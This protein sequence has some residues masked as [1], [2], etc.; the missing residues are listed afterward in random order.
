MDPPSS[1]WDSLRKQARIFE[2]QLDDQMHSY[3]KLVSTK[4]DGTES[5][6]ESGIDRLLKQLQQVNLQM[7]A[8]VSSGGSDIF[9]HT[10]TR[11]QEILQDLNQE[12]HRLRSSL[13]AKQEHASLLQ[14]F[15]EFDRTRLDLEDGVGS[16]EQALLREHA[17]INRNTGQ[18]VQRAKLSENPN[19]KATLGK[20]M[21]IIDE[22]RVTKGQ[23]SPTPLSN[24]EVL[25]N[26][27]L[28]NT[29]G[30]KEEEDEINVEVIEEG[31]K[32]WKNTIV[33]YFVGTYVSFYAVRDKIK[34]IWDIKGSLVIS[35]KDSV[36]FF[37][38]GDHRERDKVLQGG[39]WHVGDRYLKIQKWSPF[40]SIEDEKIEKIPIW[41][42]LMNLPKHCCI[43]NA[44]GYIASA[45]GT[46]ILGY[47]Y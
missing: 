29:I 19:S 14:D 5:D 9:S 30:V 37:I 4:V 2:A 36:F 38:F 17:A 27:L 12:F 20:N 33:G 26:S 15:M 21:V 42:K 3:R 11:H 24:A 10:L 13:K 22:I 31:I 7:K 32:H 16:E 23:N 45:I 46:I 35:R 8:W 44:L 6:V 40:A 39:P 43:H 18:R 41:V 25:K 47:C 34:E 28:E 1:S